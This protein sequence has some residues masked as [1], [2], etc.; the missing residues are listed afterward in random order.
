[1]I[2]LL[3]KPYD[4]VY[5][6]MDGGAG[7]ANA[8]Y[9]AKILAENIK[10]AQQFQMMI[11]Q[12]R[13]HKEYL[14]MINA[15]IENAVGLLTTLPVKDERIL[16]ELR[17]FQSASK[18]IEDLYGVVPKS[19]E[20]Q[21]QFLHD[22]TIAESLRMVNGVKDYSQIQEEN[23]IKISIQSRQASPKGAERM[24]VE[25]SAQILHTLNQLLRVNGQILKLQSEQF[26]SSNKDGKDSVKGFNKVNN[27]LQ[28]N[29]SS[30]RGNFNFPRF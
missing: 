18:T 3:L 28:V 21:L 29:L 20:A 6:Q 11:E 26:A 22:Q 2:S 17:S 4:N 30:F 12:S 7:W 10:H 27:D 1:M 23:A 9:L 24:N 16:A 8:A 25:T 14:Q 13:T 19:K 15:G 5:A